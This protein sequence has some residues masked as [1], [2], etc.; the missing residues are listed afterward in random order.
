MNTK[1]FIINFDYSMER[2]KEQTKIL[3]A[4]SFPKILPLLHLEVNQ[5]F[6]KAN[7]LPFLCESLART[8]PILPLLTFA[9]L[10]SALA[11]FPLLLLQNLLLHGFL[12]PPPTTMLKQ[13]YLLRPQGLPRNQLLLLHCHLL[14]P[15]AHPFGRI[16]SRT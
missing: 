10:V 14:P 16:P 9:V 13:L 15:L 2:I 12:H 8:I 1:L 5:T 6:A 11:K 4:R 7:L 3:L